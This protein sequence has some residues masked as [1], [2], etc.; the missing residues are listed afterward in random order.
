MQQLEPTSRKD[1][2]VSFRCAFI[3]LLIIM[4]MNIYSLIWYVSVFYLKVFTV[5]CLINILMSSLF[6]CISLRRPERA[7]EGTYR[8]INPNAASCHGNLGKTTATL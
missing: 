3:S 1:N 8:S 5:Q 7:E 2:E 6:L 4:I